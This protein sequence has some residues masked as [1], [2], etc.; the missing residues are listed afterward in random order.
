MSCAPLA[1]ASVTDRAA[2]EVLVMGVATL[3][4]VLIVVAT[5]A[6][7]HADTL[8]ETETDAHRQ[9]HAAKCDQDR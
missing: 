7:R 2:R 9:E 5:L 1:A 4:L 3:A 6:F 8:T